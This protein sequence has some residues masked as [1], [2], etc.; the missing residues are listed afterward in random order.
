MSP[1]S[2]FRLT[3]DGLQRACDTSPLPIERDESLWAITSYFN[4]MGYQ[5][6]RANYRAFRQ[7]LGVPL[8]AVE[9]GY[10]P[11]FELTERDADIL[12]QVRGR[13]V[14]WQK[15]RLLNIALSAL[16]SSC[17]KVIWADCDII[18]DG[19]AWAERVSR[20]LDRFTLV[21]AFSRAHHLS[22]TWTPADTQASTLF[23]QP[24]AVV[25]ITSGTPAANLFGLPTV[26]GPGS[27]NNGLAWGARRDLLEQTGFYDASIVGG[28]D[29]AMV[30]AAYGRFD[31]VMRNMNAK[32]QEHYLAWAQPCH[33]MVRGETS[34]VD[35]RLFHLWHGDI[36][37]RRYRHRH[38]GLRHYGFDPVEDIAHDAN[39][40]WRWNTDKADMH[41][42]VRRYF[43]SRKEDG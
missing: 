41:E 11:G 35:C 6:R 27:T 28:G 22:A 9:L 34:F 3:V 23:T 18:V 36:E 43:A 5:R 14:M 13:D 29:H 15:E 38:D 16:P 7:R 37:N 20:L 31:T 24:S 33:E 4:P 42:Y 26:R 30:C 25:T 1:G 40:V 10:G 19:E 2:T 21:Q 12:I 17:R 32:Q 39:G 8:V